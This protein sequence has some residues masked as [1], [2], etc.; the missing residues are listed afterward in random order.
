MG[1]SYLLY[2]WVNVKNGQEGTP[3]SPKIHAS[4]KRSRGSKKPPTRSVKKMK[5]THYLNAEELSKEMSVGFGLDKEWPYHHI[6]LK[7]RIIILGSNAESSYQTLN[8]NHQ[9]WPK[10]QTFKIY[11]VSTNMGPSRQEFEVYFI[12]T[13][14]HGFFRIFNWSASQ[15]R[16]DDENPKSDLTSYEEDFFGYYDDDSISV[17]IDPKWGRELDSKGEPIYT[18]E[19][20][21]WDDLFFVRPPSALQLNVECTLVDALNFSSSNWILFSQRSIESQR[22]LMQKVLAGP[23]VE[24]DS[25]QWKSTAEDTNEYLKTILADMMVKWKTCFNDFPYIY[26]IATILDSC[27][28]TKNLTKLIG[29]YY[30]SLDRPHSDVHNYIGNHKMLLVELY[31]YYSS[32]LVDNSVT[33]LRAVVIYVDSS[34]FRLTNFEKAKIDKGLQSKGKLVLDVSTRWNSTYDMIHRALEVKDAID[35]YLVRERDIDVDIISENEWDTLQDICDFL[36]PFYE[37]TKLF[38]GSKYPTAN[39]YLSCIICIEKILTDSHQDPSDAVRKMAAPM[40]EMFDKYWSDHSMVLSF[41]FLLDPRFK[42]T[43]LSD[44]YS[45]LYVPTAV[46]QKVNDV[47]AA[48]VALYECYMNTTQSAPVA[49]SPSNLG[50]PR[51][52]Q[53][54]KLRHDFPRIS[55]SRTARGDV[56]SYLAMSLVVD[57]DGF[58]VLEYWKGQSTS[59]PTLALMARD[60]LAIP[61]TSVASESAF[62]V[63]GRILNK[64]RS[65]LLPKNVEILVTTRNWLF[66]FEPEEN[67]KEILS[68]IEENNTDHDDNAS[69]TLSLVEQFL[70]DY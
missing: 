20:D 16:F 65:S 27:L 70:T 45:M 5:V 60:I 66:G 69:G 55:A 54:R 41:A 56:D 2:S 23:Q 3:I 28:K 40:W 29:F 15:K 59:Y 67:A 4:S 39:L 19:I 22:K 8:L 10:G 33:K 32:K 53:M 30:H 48:F 61:I 26:E 37:I 25:E 21:L 43:F 1:V 6:R 24:A 52:F 36:E 58:D 11:R 42:M 13:L 14:L 44:Y 35:L 57:Y 18:P 38:S 34:D 9:K 50:P 51:P 17:E 62:S 46:E 63:G 64:L 31:D 7:C 68:V 12:Q 49:P 47:L